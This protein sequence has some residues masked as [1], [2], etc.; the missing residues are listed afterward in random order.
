MANKTHQGFEFNMQAAKFWPLAWITILAKTCDVVSSLVP[1]S[2]LSFPSS[3][4]TVSGAFPQY[5]NH[6]SSFIPLLDICSPH[7]P[8]VIHKIQCSSGWLPDLPLWLQAQSTPLH[9]WYFPWGRL[10]APAFILCNAHLHRHL[11]TRLWCSLTQ[12]TTFYSSVH[13][14]GTCYSEG[15]WET[16]FKWI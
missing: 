9:L 4:L 5:P 16:F 2:T 3:L 1:A 15:G 12:V 8:K 13:V 10:H 6:S 11:P 7:P 14:W